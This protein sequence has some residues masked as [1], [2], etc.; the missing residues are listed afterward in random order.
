MRRLVAWRE[1]EDGL[2][3]D[4]NGFLG[5]VYLRIGDCGV[6]FVTEEGVIRVTASR[7]V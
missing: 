4:T 6:T 3:R 5:P 2:R 1:S 7:F